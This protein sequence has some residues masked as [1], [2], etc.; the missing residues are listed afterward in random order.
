MRL[1]GVDVKIWNGSKTAGSAF[2]QGL[3]HVLPL[4]TALVDLGLQAAEMAAKTTY[5]AR[6]RYV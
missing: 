3:R 5:A 6:M 4:T 2:D 1:M